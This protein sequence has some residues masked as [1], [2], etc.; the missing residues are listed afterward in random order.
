MNDISSFSMQQLNQL[1]FWFIHCDISKKAIDLLSTS[2]WKTGWWYIKRATAR[3]LH[4]LNPPHFMQDFVGDIG[5]WWDNVMPWA[6]LAL[7]FVRISNRFK[8]AFYSKAATD[9][10]VTCILIDAILCGYLYTV[11]LL[12]EFGFI[13]R[14]CLE[15]LSERI[16]QR[17]IKWIWSL[18]TSIFKKL[19]TCIRFRQRTQWVMSN[20]LNHFRFARIAIHFLHWCIKSALIVIFVG[21]LGPYN[22]IVK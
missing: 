10:E 3:W 21:N 9:V 13:W 14:G 20:K 4:H 15:I 6:M 16:I 22:I 11:W 8:N 19:V 12:Y 7:K 2:L 17:S 1:K 18:G 5:W